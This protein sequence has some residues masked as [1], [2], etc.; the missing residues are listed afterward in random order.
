MGVWIIEERGIAGSEIEYGDEI[1][2]I[3]KPHGYRRVRVDNAGVD[4]YYVHESVK[5]PENGLLKEFRE[6]P[7]G[8]NGC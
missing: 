8:S 5:I 4:G 1:E 7:E 2:A 6:H 3:L